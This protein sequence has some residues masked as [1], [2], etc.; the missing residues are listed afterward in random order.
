[1]Q[2]R[3]FVRSYL[4]GKK[5]KIRSFKTGATRDTDEG[6]HDFEG[7]LSPTVINRF[8]EYMTKNRIQSDGSLRDS[9]N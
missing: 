7:Y 4:A 2:R 5:G 3:S 8:G 1:M 9:D 6:K